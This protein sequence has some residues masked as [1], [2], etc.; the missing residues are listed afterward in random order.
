LNTFGAQEDA[1]LSSQLDGEA[2]V[3]E[4]GKSLGKA[5]NPHVKNGSPK[6][7][8]GQKRFAKRQLSGQS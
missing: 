1:A 7:I 5:I 6:W 8:K 4:I 3:R 2:V